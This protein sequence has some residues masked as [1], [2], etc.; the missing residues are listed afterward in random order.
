MQPPSEEC[1]LP[2]YH[3][4]PHWHSLQATPGMNPSLYFICLYQGKLNSSNAIIVPFLQTTVLTH[5]NL[6]SSATNMS[7]HKCLQQNRY[8]RVKKN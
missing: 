1:S 7:T 4:P 8:N 2:W 5:I 6:Q 3:D